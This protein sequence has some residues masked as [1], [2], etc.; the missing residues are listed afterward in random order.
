VALR[1]RQDTGHSADLQR[2]GLLVLLKSGQ[3]L[4]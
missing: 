1:G 3:R 2:A 4:K